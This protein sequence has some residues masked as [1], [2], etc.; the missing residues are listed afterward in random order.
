VSGGEVD[1]SGEA[2]AVDVEL[3]RFNQRN[4]K[5]ALPGWKVV[6]DR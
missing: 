5:N 1:V 6:F 4:G 3:M 2:V